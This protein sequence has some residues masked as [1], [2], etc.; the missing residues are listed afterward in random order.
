MSKKNSSLNFFFDWL[1]VIVWLVII[2]F[3]SNQPNLKSTLEPLWDFVFRK[4]AHIIEYF[5][6]TFLFVR[7]LKNY[8]LPLPTVTFSAG[9]LALIS[10]AFD[11]SHQ[12]FIL[13][14]VGSPLDLL[15]DSI[16]II[17][18]LLSALFSR[19]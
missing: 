15:I 18:L 14:R 3:F 17:L 16:G 1:A 8:H 5:V 19:L 2:Y 7:A 9:V 13:G 4:I 12:L 11:E 6:L 10:A